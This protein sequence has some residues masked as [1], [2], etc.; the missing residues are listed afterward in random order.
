M[1][2]I[3]PSNEREQDILQMGYANVWFSFGKERN[4]PLG[5]DGPLLSAEGKKIKVDYINIFFP[6]SFTGTGWS[7]LL[8]FCWNVVDE[9]EVEWII[10][11]RELT[12][13]WRFKIVLGAIYI[14][15]WIKIV[16]K[17][18]YFWYY[19][20]EF[21]EHLLLFKHTIIYWLSL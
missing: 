3:Q 16:T 17:Y 21:T 6:S 9:R 4:W 1:W 13:F 19:A 5:Y 2:W 12:L 20:Q 7:F 15:S 11:A 18:R 10:L 8:V 14:L